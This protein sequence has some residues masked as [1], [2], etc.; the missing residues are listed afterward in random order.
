MSLSPVKVL[1]A[2]TSASLAAVGGLSSTLH[3]EMSEAHEGWVGNRSLPSAR[4]AIE[5]DT[6]PRA[7]FKCG[8][9]WD[10]MQF[11]YGNLEN[12][13]ALVILNPR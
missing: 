12:S 2:V 10:L 4:A 11:D 13:S 9:Y 6:V 7:L 1:G 8:R 5:G 3:R